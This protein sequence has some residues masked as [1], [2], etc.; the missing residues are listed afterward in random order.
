MGETTG[1]PLDPIHIRLH[2]TEYLPYFEIINDALEFEHKGPRHNV[3]VI[4]PLRTRRQSVGYFGPLRIARYGNEKVRFSKTARQRQRVE[5]QL[6]IISGA[7][8][9]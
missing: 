6:L 7:T 8:H 1:L 3:R 9:E 2:L 4:L 5:I